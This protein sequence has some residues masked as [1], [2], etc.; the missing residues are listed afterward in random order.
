MLIKNEN[1]RYVLFTTTLVNREKVD[2]TLFLVG[3]D[4]THWEKSGFVVFL[5]N[6]S[7]QYNFDALVKIAT[8]INNRINKLI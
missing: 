5:L 2:N 7:A 4:Y 8:S 6:E 3:V 1:G